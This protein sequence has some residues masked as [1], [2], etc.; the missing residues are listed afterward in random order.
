MTTQD[1]SADTVYSIVPYIGGVALLCLWIWFWHRW[2]KRHPEGVFDFL[3]QRARSAARHV[4]NRTLNWHPGQVVLAWT[5]AA[6]IEWLMW[7][8]LTLLLDVP[9]PTMAATIVTFAVLFL[10]VAI[11][12][13]MFVVTW[14]WF[15]GR[16]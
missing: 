10:V 12:V 4:A 13:S 11:P 1:V 16:T 2:G 6:L 8:W 7:Q 14:K 9:G 3:E 15:G 5:G